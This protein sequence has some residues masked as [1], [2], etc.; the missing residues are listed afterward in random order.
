M[1]FLVTRRCAVAVLS[2]LLAGCG[3][4]A[5][6]QPPSLNL[7][8]PVVDLS[9]VRIGN[10]VNLSWTMPAR[11][12]DRVALR[13]PITVQVCRSADKDPCENIAKLSFP[14]GRAGAYTDSLP[15]QLTEEPERLLR[16][17]VFLPNHA[18]KSAGPSNT[19][20][21]ASGASPPAVTGLSG[22]VRQEG[23]LLTWQSVE[24]PG[25]PIFF[26]ID[27]LQL[28]AAAP[29]ETPRSPLSPDLPR[30]TQILEVRGKNGGDPG[31]ALDT[32]VLFNQRY[33]YVLERVATRDGGPI[34]VEGPP[35]AA[36][37]VTTRDTFPPAVPRGLVAVADA[38]GG[39]IDLSWQPDTEADLA[40]YMVY[41]RDL[42]ASLPA[43]RIASVGVETSFRDTAVQPGHTYAY[44]VSAIDQ[45]GNPSASSPDVEE[46]L[47]KQP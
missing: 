19:A 47:P 25:R 15:A 29:Q 44:S 21:S 45:S 8:T 2:L 36:I 32:S 34:E 41:R 10:S 20:L 9:A 3:A 14:P 26:R 5:A 4:P 11:T 23:V 33:R 35:S 46:T 38:A 28:T 18:G 7:P 27:R 12:T 24:P 6:P 37:E 40:A 1:K 43:Q 22:E 13:R 31:H 30:A 42:P 16:Y 39:A 17:Q